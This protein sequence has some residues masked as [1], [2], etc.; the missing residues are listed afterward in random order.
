MVSLADKI[1]ECHLK[2]SLTPSSDAAVLFLLH[3]GETDLGITGR[4]SLP[5]VV[6]L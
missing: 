1:Y 6:G 3:L 4:I 5:A 2:M